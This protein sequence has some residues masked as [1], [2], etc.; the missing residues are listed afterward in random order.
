MNNILQNKGNSHEYNSFNDLHETT[1]STRV[2]VAE[3]HESFVSK[4]EALT[5]TEISLSDYE[6]VNELGHFIP[7]HFL[8]DF[9]NGLDSLIMSILKNVLVSQLQTKIIHVVKTFSVPDED[10]IRFVDNVDIDE[11]LPIPVC[12]NITPNEPVPFLLHLMLMLGKFETELDLHITGSI[13][14]NLYYAKLIGKEYNNPNS[15]HKYVL[16][17]TRKFIEEVFL[18]QPITMRRLNKFI[19]MSYQLFLNIIK[20][21]EIPITDLPPCLLTVM[22]D[23]KDKDLIDFSNEKIN[24]MQY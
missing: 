7:I 12:S 19:L 23:T 8:L 22:L 11:L 4:L 5:S 13:R 24:F 1:Q 21:N 20:D 15:Q 10:W 2:V 6:L 3:E 17:L 18:V 14:E 16:D 9:E